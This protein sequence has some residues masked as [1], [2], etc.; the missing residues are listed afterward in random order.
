MVTTNIQ[1]L[2]GNWIAGWALDL[3][4]V[5]SHY[6]ELRDSYDTLRTPIG[7]ILY[8]LKYNREWWL[9]RKLAAVAVEFLKEKGILQKIDNI[10]TIPPSKFRLFFQPVRSIGKRMGKLTGLPVETRIIRMAKRLPPMKEI[11]DFRQRA[12]LVRDMFT[13]KS[14]KL[15]HKTVLLFDDLYRSGLTLKEGARVLRREAGVKSI[16][17]LTITKTR[18]RK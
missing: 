15:E 7:E 3:H 10:V 4:T 8:R 9:A 17:V 13:V 11:E 5:S 14:R 12:E 18:I 16:Y 2:K 1:E 6:D